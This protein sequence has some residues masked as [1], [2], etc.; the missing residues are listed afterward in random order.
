M[1]KKFTKEL[2]WGGILGGVFVLSVIVY[3]FTGAGQVN[4]V[5]FFPTEGT[6]ELSGELRRV[7]RRG[8]DEENI[9]LLVEEL[10]LG[11]VELSLNPLIP[12][13]TTVRTCMF[14]D[15]T[16]YLDLSPELIVGKGSVELSVDESLAGV[17]RTIRF[18]FPRVEDIVFFIDGEM[19]DFKPSGMESQTGLI[20]G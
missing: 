10:I 5:L 18:N 1:K 13:Y 17:D 15:R 6:M 8:S 3:I 2:L 12:K 19:Y 4:R 9:E 20:S 16:V 14:R 11:P 7:P